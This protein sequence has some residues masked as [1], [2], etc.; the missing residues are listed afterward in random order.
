MCLRCSACVPPAT[1]P[2]RLIHPASWTPRRGDFSLSGAGLAP[3]LSQK[4]WI[5]ALLASAGCRRTRHAAESAV[6]SQVSSSSQTAGLCNNALFSLSGYMYG[7]G[8]AFAFLHHSSVQHFD[9]YFGAHFRPNQARDIPDLRKQL[10]RAMSRLSSRAEASEISRQASGFIWKQL[11]AKPRVGTEL[12]NDALARALSEKTEFTA[13]EW[14]SFKLK[15]LRS[16]HFIAA[17]NWD[18]TANLWSHSGTYFAPAFR[19]RPPA[20]T[21]GVTD[22]L[23]TS[24]LIAKAEANALLKRPLAKPRMD[25]N[26]IGNP[27]QNREWHWYCMPKELDHRPDGSVWEK[28]KEPVEGNS[29]DGIKTKKAVSFTLMP[30]WAVGVRGYIPSPSNPPSHPTFPRPP[31][32]SPFQISSRPALHMIHPA[33]VSLT[34]PPTLSSLLRCGCRIV[35]CGRLLTM[36]YK[37]DEP[38]SKAPHRWRMLKSNDL[39]GTVVI[40]E[41]RAIPSFGGNP[42]LK[43]FLSIGDAWFLL[44]KKSSLMEDGMIERR[45]ADNSEP[46]RM[47]LV[48]PQSFFAD[49][50]DLGIGVHLFLKDLLFMTAVFFV[51]GAASFSKSRA[52]TGPTNLLASVMLMPCYVS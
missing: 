42:K 2:S 41:A 31:H 14:S 39:P 30:A 29:Q 50:R 24:D 22:A 33:G 12:T 44:P 13:L 1:T 5:T 52:R 23:E 40:R 26:V 17:K 32:P 36:S 19:E 11:Q 34:V 10:T 8:G 38:I 25:V 21:D 18:E 49:S 51:M 37:G 20:K 48:R 3:S 15:D 27:P 16:D 6:R 43:H 28:V 47:V 4:R 35:L 45:S 7:Q 9:C 46:T